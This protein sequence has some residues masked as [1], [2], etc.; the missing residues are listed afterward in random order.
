M[1]N[2]F[3]EFLPSTKKRCW[4]NFYKWNLFLWLC[5]LSLFREEWEWVQSLSANDVKESP[6][7]GQ[8]NFHNLLTNSC[9]RLLNDLGITEDDAISHRLYDLE[10]IEL[11]GNV[12][13]L[14]LLPPVEHVCSVPGHNDEL[15]SKEGF[16]TPP[17]Q[18]FEMGKLS[19]SLHLFYLVKMYINSQRIHTKC[20][21][22]HRIHTKCTLIHRIH[23]KCTLIHRGF[24][25][26]LLEQISFLCVCWNAWFSNLIIS[27]FLYLKM[28]ALLLIKICWIDLNNIIILSYFFKLL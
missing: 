17:V 21:L 27:S 10:V 15:S 2:A 25:Q 23:T 4:I 22:I 8:V 7:P 3:A 5:C 13:F 1:K 28:A 6:T 20:T 14:L 9:K 18:V 26:N 11:S 19:P 24:I 12:S 16:L